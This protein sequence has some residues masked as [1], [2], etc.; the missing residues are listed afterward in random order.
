MVG[1][2]VDLHATSAVEML[3]HCGDDVVWME[4]SKIFPLFFFLTCS[5]HMQTNWGDFRSESLGRLRPPSPGI[6]SAA[7]N[8]RHFSASK[9]KGQMDWCKNRAGADH[10]RRPRYG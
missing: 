1:F 10:H 3:A 9:A 5:L 6:W 8:P 2:F 7:P 4:E